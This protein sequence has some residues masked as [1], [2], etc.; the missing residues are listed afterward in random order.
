MVKEYK[1]VRSPALRVLLMIAGGICVGLGVIGIFLPILPTTPFL[2]LA[3]ACFVRS[4]EQFHQWLLNH[5]SL[6]Q[7]IL[8][9]LDGSGMPRK[10]KKY[11]L[12]ML[13]LTMPFAI[14]LVPLM[15]VR[16]LL[17]LIGLSVSFYIIRLPVAADT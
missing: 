8:P 7:Y 12:M 5:P 15:P 16:I 6:G 17:A 13:W 2:L 14:Y 1:Q 11:T 9:Y 3:A 4:S 10:A